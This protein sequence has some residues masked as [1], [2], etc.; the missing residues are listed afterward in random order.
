MENIKKNNYFEL[1]KAFL[2]ILSYLFIIPEIIALLFYN[3]NLDLHNLTINLI[4][5]VLV[6]VCIFK[7]FGSLRLE[8]YLK[9]GI[10]E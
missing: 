5:N 7:Y 2:L 1:G 3:L 4:A 10:G 6:Y 8:D 9:I